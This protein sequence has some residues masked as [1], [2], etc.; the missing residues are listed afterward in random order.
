M[1][2]RSRPLRGKAAVA[3]VGYAGLGQP[4]G[5]SSLELLAE[6]AGTALADAGLTLAD[7]DGLCAGTLYHFFP[8]LSVAEYVGIRPKWADADMI[9]GGSFLSHVLQAA[10]ALDAGLCEVALIAY[11]SDARGSRNLGGD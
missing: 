10:M 3:G 2:Q 5:R 4:A 7:V 9:G 6:A 1:L 8:T 11:G